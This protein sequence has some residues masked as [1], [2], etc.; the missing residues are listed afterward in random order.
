MRTL[1]Q[2]RGTIVKIGDEKAKSEKFHVREFEL[3]ISDNDKDNI[4]RFQLSGDRV[5]LIDPY[6]EGEDIVVW[7]YLR[8]SYWREKYFMNLD[9]QRIESG[10]PNIL[11][12]TQNLA[13][14][15]PI[16]S[17]ITSSDILPDPIGAG[18]YQLGQ[19]RDVYPDDI[20]N[21]LF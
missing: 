19:K 12:D 6:C 11:P 5:D 21:T 18:L 3:N 14:E 1:H 13:I 16:G 17:A 15:D 20:D 2:Q 10:N 4:I 9:V 8:G 7:F